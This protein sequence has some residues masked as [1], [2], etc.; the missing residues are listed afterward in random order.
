MNNAHKLLCKSEYRENLGQLLDFLSLRGT[1]ETF[2]T[3]W[4]NCWNKWRKNNG[5]VS[6]YEKKLKNRIKTSDVSRDEKLIHCFYKT[7]N[8]NILQTLE[9]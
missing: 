4:L 2:D 9:G 3:L 8:I 1:N 5:N 6:S 7:V